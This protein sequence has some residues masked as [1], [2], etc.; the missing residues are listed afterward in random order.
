M[1]NSGS[2][3]VGKDGKVVSVTT[4][5]LKARLN[6]LYETRKHTRDT[7]SL[8][9]YI[10]D[11]KEKALME[12]RREVEVPSTWLDDLEDSVRSNEDQRSLAH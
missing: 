9:E 4:D 1:S 12:G 5:R 3:L 8:F 2:N 6:K 10:W 11:L 7:D